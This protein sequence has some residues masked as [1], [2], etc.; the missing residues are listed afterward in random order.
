MKTRLA[1]FVLATLIIAGCNTTKDTTSGNKFTS[2]TII[3]T[4]WELTKLDGTKVDQSTTT[5]KKIH[6]SL[7]S[8]VN[9]VN[10]HAGCNTFYGNYTLEKGNRIR[11][12]KLVS[13]RMACLDAA[14]DESN[15]LEVFQLA[16]NY[17]INGD[18]LMLN[19]GRRTPLAVFR[20]VK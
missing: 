12:A 3:D 17:T 10:G 7:N 13:T 18:T 9:R 4:T 16:D 8:A 14:I 15:L 2:A 1:I 19:I 11:F 20:K 5:G 6:F